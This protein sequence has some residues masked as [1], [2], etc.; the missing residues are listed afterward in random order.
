MVG[1]RQESQ[2]RARCEKG[3]EVGGEFVRHDVVGELA[4]SMIQKRC[5]SKLAVLM[6]SCHSG[7]KVVASQGGE[8]AGV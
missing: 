3:E 7:E 1:R 5:S 8:I 6:M 2:R 4:C